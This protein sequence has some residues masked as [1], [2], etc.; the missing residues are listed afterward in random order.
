MRTTRRRELA[1]VISHTVHH[2]ALIAVLVALAGGEIPEA[3][4]LA[5][6]T[7]RLRS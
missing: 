5:P 4:G 7:P 6:T 2:Q 1:F 3:F